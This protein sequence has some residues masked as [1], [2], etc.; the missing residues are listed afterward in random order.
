MD[1]TAVR[2]AGRRRGQPGEGIEASSTS[3]MFVS[4]SRLS[5]ASDAD[6][7]DMSPSLEGSREYS[8]NL[9]NYELL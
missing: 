7:T 1:E 2:E 8:G 4:S 9:L 5:D 6:R 3:M